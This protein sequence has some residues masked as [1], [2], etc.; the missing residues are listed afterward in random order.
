MMSYKKV[1]PH[2]F[3]ENKYFAYTK[4]HQATLLSIRSECGENT[5]QNNSKYGHFSRQ[6]TSKITSLDNNIIHKISFEFT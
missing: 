6:A 5:D 4:Q 2:T 1:F 3:F